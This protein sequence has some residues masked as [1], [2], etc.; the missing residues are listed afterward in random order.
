VGR[1]NVQ[2]LAAISSLLFLFLTAC[3]SNAQATG[4][5]LTVGLT[6]VPNIQF[7]PVYVADAL[8]YYRDAGLSVTIRH[9]AL[10]EDEF[11]ALVSGQEN[12]IYAGGD[13]VVQARSKG[14]SLTYLA[15][16]YTTYPVTLIV[17]ANSPIYTAADLRGHSIG[18]PGPY[19]A[20]YIGLLSLLDNA[21]L[22]TKDVNIQ[23]INYTQVPALMGGKVDSVV[24]FINN[25]PV[26][27]RE[28][29]FAVRTLP[30]FAP[31]APSFISN[32][33]AALTSELTSH[34]DDVKQFV[35][36]TLRGVAY[37]NAH[38]Q[39]AV[40]LSQKYVPGMQTAN[41]L[42]V[43]QAS[44]PLWQNAGNPQNLADWQAMAQFLQAKGFLSDSVDPSVCFSNDYLPAKSA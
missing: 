19:G 38:P 12:I 36:A 15:S 37:V 31:D 25:E 27:F 20:S 40:R 35:A 5:H 22:T 26:Q 39:D 7:A 41:A 1:R 6:Y 29:D 2:W 16:I 33:L 21:R 44:I 18:I 14:I 28:H 34:K 43:L 3:G 32:G 42:A 4:H 24:G 9:H 8:G 10:S 23:Y 17:P 11:G 30:M 13:E